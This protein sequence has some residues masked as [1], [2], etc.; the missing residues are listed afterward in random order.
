LYHFR[1]KYERRVTSLAL[2]QRIN[3]NALAEA[4]VIAPG[5]KNLK[6]ATQKMMKNRKIDTDWSHD[7]E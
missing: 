4:I 2:R 6:H 3:S 1:N 5:G 7:L